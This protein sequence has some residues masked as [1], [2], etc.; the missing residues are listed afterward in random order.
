[1]QPHSMCALALAN[2]CWNYNKNIEL[3]KSREMQVEYT[4]ADGRFRSLYYKMT[5]IRFQ[6][7]QKEFSVNILRSNGGYAC[8]MSVKINSNKQCEM[9]HGNQ[10]V[11]G[12]KEEFELW[13]KEIKN[14]KHRNSKR[15]GTFSGIIFDADKIVLNCELKRDGKESV[16][17]KY[18]LKIPQLQ[19]NK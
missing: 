12:Y 5:D 2:L 19:F 8:N 14:G 11:A 18:T 10:H 15:Y 4:R 13:L 1:M 16:M 7:E 17:S 3:L 6:T 9:S